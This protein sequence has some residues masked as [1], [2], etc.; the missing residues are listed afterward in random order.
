MEREYLLRNR[1]LETKVVLFGS[2]GPTSKRKVLQQ[3]SSS[4]LIGRHFSVGNLLKLPGK[5]GGQTSPVQRGKEGTHSLLVEVFGAPSGLPQMCFTEYYFVLKVI[6]FPGA[7]SGK[8]PTN[9]G[10]DVRDWG[11]ISGLGISWRRAQQHTIL[12]WRIPSTEEPS[13]Q[14]SIGLPKSQT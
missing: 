8:E 2:S 1:I 14:Q 11:L 3:S 10:G 6:G 9:N 12:G 4:P 13:G 5:Q 7:I